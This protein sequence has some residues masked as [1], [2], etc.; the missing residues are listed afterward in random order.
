MHAPH[1]AISAETPKEKFLVELLDALWERYRGRVEY[2]R[3][4]ETL[5]ES[6]G[7]VFLNDHIAFRTFALQDP[8]CGIFSIARLGDRDRQTDL[9]IGLLVGP[10]KLWVLELLL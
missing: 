3:K 6:L 2:A 9:G 1:R 4:Y 5:I 8:A 10:P 7:A